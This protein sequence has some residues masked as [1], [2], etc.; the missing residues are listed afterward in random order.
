[1]NKE[2]A[3]RFLDS[4]RHER[5]QDVETTS[6]LL[7]SLP[8]SKLVFEGYAITNL[9]LENIRTGLAGKLYLELGPDHAIDQ[10]INRGDIKVGDIVIIK[11]KGSP[12]PRGKRIS[13]QKEGEK[14]DG[15]KEV[16]Q[17]SGVIV[18]ISD[19]QL[20]V[21]IEEMHEE[22]AMKLFAFQRLYVLK[23]T[24][25]ITYQ[26][27]ES[28]MNKL[29]EFDSFPDNQIVQYLLN[30]R[31]FH[32]QKISD[33]IKFRNSSLNEPQKEAVKFALAND[34]SIIH[35]P[36]GTGKT[37]T[38]IEIIQQLCERGQRVLVCGPSNI[39]VDTILERLA[40]VLP[41][42][43]L[44]RI[45]H[46]A[47]LLETNLAHS[48]DVLSKNGDAGA[49]VKDISSEIDKKISGIKKLKFSKDRKQGWNDVKELRKELRQRERKVIIDL[50][51]EAKVVV[52]TLHGSSSRQLSSIYNQVP[53][54]FDA[55]IIDEVSQSMEPQCW[56]PLIS[57]YK[58]DIRKLILA[59]D[60]MQ[61][62][63]TI[64]TCDD[65]SIKRTLSTTLFDRL[66]RHYGD[67]FKCLL[68]VQ[69]R[70]NEQ[71]MTF[72]SC[73]LYNQKLIADTSVA[74]LVVS[75]LPGVDINDDTKKPLI[76]YDTQGDDFF[77]NACQDDTASSKFNESEALLVKG[78]IEILIESNV[79]QEAI[80]VIAPYS[81]QVSLLKKLIHEKLPLIEISTVDGFQGREKEVIILSLVRSNDKFEVGFL[82][83]ERRLNV[84]MTR[85][86]KQLCV[87]G[88]I[89]TLERSHQKFLKN[90]AEWSE[91]NADIRYPDIGELL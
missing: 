32:A 13:K 75:D 60:N 86:K 9:V 51:L 42:N 31:T 1:M 53:K 37:F 83:E 18:K 55:L 24:N 57:H 23:T 36:P 54:Y 62:P 56:I 64:K 70:M 85:A 50:L 91:E 25:T 76:W 5:D 43:L 71:I 90:W 27:M 80:G 89:E 77:E 59:G 34:I 12:K 41:G 14:Y 67:S 29:A 84:A 72:P 88:N 81:A 35:G 15:E 39:S 17:C 58:S 30:G 22:S 8:L 73:A 63:P 4:I 2:L 21:T 52:C 87:I 47:R 7:N 33:E 46:P 40:K 49:I 48:L 38:L 45:G 82:K 78:H 11:P 65:K 66:V 79:S 3:D 69:Y 20:I 26:R 68:T 6:K 44:L 19:R 10:E 28:T 74:T 61:L 16:Y